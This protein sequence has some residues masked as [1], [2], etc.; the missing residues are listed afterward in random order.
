MAIQNLP[1]VSTLTGSDL[2]PLFSVALGLDS[3]A[4]LNVLLQW[5]AENGGTGGASEYIDLTDAATVSLPTV[6]TPLSNALAGKQ[7]TLTAGANITILPDGTISASGSGGSTPIVNDLT[8]GGISSALS[9]QMGVTIKGLIDALTS[10]DALKAPIASPTLTGTPAAPTAASVTN[11]TQIATTAFVQ[12]VV[13]AAVT[14]LLDL[15]TATDCSGNPNYPAALKGDAY[16]VSVAGRIGGASGKQVEV[17]DLYFAVADNAGG[18]EA[19]VGTNWIAME[20]NLVGAALTSGTL[21]Q[22]ASTTSAQLFTLLSTKTGSGGNSVF[23]QGPTIDSLT[24]TGVSTAPGAVIVTPA[25]MAALVIDVTSQDNTKS[26]AVDST[27]T[28]SAAGTTG[29]VFGITIQNTD[30]VQHTIT[31]P[32]AGT[33]FSMG[34][35]AVATTFILPA[36]ARAAIL[37]K[38]TGAN[39]YNM[40]ADPVPLRQIAIPFLFQTGG[41]D[42]Q[43]V[44]PFSAAAGSLVRIR[45]V[46]TSGTAT[47]QVAINGT[48]VTATTSS[49][50]STPQNQTIT[51]LNVVAVDDVITIVRT[52]DATCVN[53]RG[54]LY[55]VPTTP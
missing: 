43:F 19:A 8:T 22:F 30:T 24:A 34:R 26:I 13:A 1:S 42:T 21:A 35:Q 36:G 17:S 29:Q 23:S 11:T 45:V 46:S 10:S 5:L 25:A 41:N 44:L 28:L 15:K 49:V 6:N 48:P 33:F 51:A 52:A 3:K 54:T 31:L 4:T 16:F 55:M 7:K 39:A 38:V 37:F 18:T 14:G 12:T 50:S 2:L 9:A 32:V 27:L 47:Y 20:H 53:G 40:W